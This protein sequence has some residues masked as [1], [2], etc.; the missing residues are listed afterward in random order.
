MANENQTILGAGK[1]RRVV[2]R[3]KILDPCCGPRGMWFDKFDERALFLDKRDEEHRN[4]YPS[5]YKCTCVHPDEIGNFT[6]IN[7]PDNSFWLVVFDPPHISRNIENPSVSGE[8]FKRYGI[9]PF[10]W[11]TE[12][13][14]G[15]AECFRVL[16]PNGTLIFKWNE[17]SISIH[18]VL[19]LTPEKPLFGHVTRR[20]L[21]THWVAFMKEDRT[22]CARGKTR[23]VVRRRQ[24][25]S[26][27]E[28]VSKSWRQYRTKVLI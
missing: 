8:T 27:A 9:L 19:A 20:N 18:D 26:H 3:K 12:L 16:K 14:K 17:V 28:I 6:S 23:R 25:Q 7:Y 4:N 1:T 24:I 15:F 11:K 10:D 22:S 5:G 21:K 2:R 13:T